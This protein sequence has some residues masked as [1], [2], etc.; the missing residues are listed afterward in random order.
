MQLILVL[1]EVV[2]KPGRDGRRKGLI[3]QRRPFPRVA[4]SADFILHL[5]QDDA[6][7][8]IHLADMAHE[9]GKG[10][11]IRLPV[12]LAEGGEGFGGSAL[13]DLRARELFLVGLDPD[14]R[15]AGDAVFPAPEPHQANALTDQLGVL[16]GR[17]Q[18]LEVVLALLG[19]DVP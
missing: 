13:P 11:G 18:D 15:E 16:D 8:P 6:V 19:F 9:G 7:R 10:A 17:I 4:E 2:Q 12:V 14:R 1:L 5:N 3:G